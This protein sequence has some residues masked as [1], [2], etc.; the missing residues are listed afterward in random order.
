MPSLSTSDAVGTATANAADASANV[1]TAEPTIQWGHGG[2]GGDEDGARGGGEIR[3]PEG[4]KMGQGLVKYRSSNVAH[5][6][7]ATRKDETR[8]AFES[9]YFTTSKIDSLID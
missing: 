6:G 1:G 5:T 4:T 8:I 3:T 9:H 2:G 7:S